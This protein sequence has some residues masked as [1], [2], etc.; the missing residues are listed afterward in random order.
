MLTFV[1]DKTQNRT[2]PSY[3]SKYTFMKLIDQLP[4]S[5]EW[6]CELVQ[7][8]SEEPIDPDAND[9]A[10]PNED[11][12]IEELKLWL[13]NP[14]ACVQELIGNPAFHGEIAYAP[15]KVYTDHHGTTRQYNEM[16]MGDWWWETQVSTLS[17]ITINR[18]WCTLTH[19]SVLF[20]C[21]SHGCT[22]DYC[23]RQDWAV[24]V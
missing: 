7:V 5:P 19:F 9:W 14:I 1:G 12:A 18:D 17:C 2:R 8:H 6:K 21:W 24:M 11:N 22:C 16:W 4:T 23:L 20:A 13:C 3:Q 10:A 15:E